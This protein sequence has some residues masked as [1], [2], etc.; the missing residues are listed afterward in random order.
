[1]TD[2]ARVLSL[3][4]ALVDLTVD[5]PS[6]PERGGDVLATGSR[7]VVGGGFNLAAA[8][9]RQGIECIYAAPHGRGPY[10]DAI[11]AAMATEGI[12]MPMPMRTEGDSGFCV[13]MLEPD[14]ER[15]FITVVGVEATVTPAELASLDRRPTDLLALSGYDLLYQ[16]SG[17]VLATWLESLPDN[18]FLALDPGP[19]VMDIPAR[20]LRTVLARTSLLTLNQREA[21][22]LS[23][24]GPLHGPDLLAATRQALNLPEATVLLLREGPS[25]ALADGGE[26]AG[27]TISV[28]VHY[29]TAVDSIGAGD[30]H[31]G[32]LLAELA[33]RTPLPVALQRANTAAAISVTRIGSATAPGR[34]EIDTALAEIDTTRAEIHTTRAGPPGQG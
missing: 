26:L 8:V 16:H 10:G 17:P 3:G 34:D 14:G 11:R 4:S 31:T 1:M 9:A 21:R 32:V 12:K 13:T 5:L 28:P 7:N 22:L 24:A 18:T 27:Q 33:R 29:V 2:E 20:R 19:L 25:G 15:S 23:G 30:T 6:L